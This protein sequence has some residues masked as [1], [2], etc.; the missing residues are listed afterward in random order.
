MF[1][2]VFC[3]QKTNL[4]KIKIRLD[5]VV[6]VGQCMNTVYFSI[7]HCKAVLSWNHRYVFSFDAYPLASFT[8]GWPSKAG[9]QKQTEKGELTMTQHWTCKDTHCAGFTNVHTSSNTV[10]CY[11]GNDG[12]GVAAVTF[13][14]DWQTLSRCRPLTCA[15]FL[16]LPYFRKISQKQ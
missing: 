9:N 13:S 15:S 14:L 10:H 12:D 8:S 3:L 7:K 1:G 6:I 4:H 11:D 16:H 2:F 5:F